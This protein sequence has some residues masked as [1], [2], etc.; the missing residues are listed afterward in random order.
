MIAA[1]AVVAK[2]EQ[3]WLFGFNARGDEPDVSDLDLLVTESQ[4][5]N[6]TAEMV[7]LRWALHPLRL[8]VDLLVCFADELSQWGAQ[9]GGALYRAVRE[10]RR[11]YG[12]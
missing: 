1:L 7:R 11:V 4:V 2:P 3:I 6:W 12:R 5:S 9:P 10:G 8:S